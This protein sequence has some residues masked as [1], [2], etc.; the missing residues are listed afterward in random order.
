MFKPL[1]GAAEASRC[2]CATLEADARPWPRSSQAEDNFGDGGWEVLRLL[3]T[4]IAATA[5]PARR[6][7]DGALFAFVEGTDPEV[8]L[9]LEAR[10]SDGTGS[11]G[12]MP[13]PR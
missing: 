7:E 8:F 11:S 12:S 2:T 1:P 4:P 5:R 6:P 13:S 3:P 9:F 10:P